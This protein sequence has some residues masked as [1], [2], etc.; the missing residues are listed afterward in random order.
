MVESPRKQEGHPQSAPGDFYVVN[1]VCISCGAPEAVAPDLIGWAD[2]GEAEPSHCIWKKQPE[3]PTELEQAI[4]AFD[5]SCCESYRYA[6]KQPAIIA[7]LPPQCCDQV[8][9][10]PDPM[11]SRWFRFFVEV[12]VGVVLTISWVIDVPRRIFRRR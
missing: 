12:L 10:P 6:G 3:T 2:V 5:A 11:D 1:D 4:A 8:E 9:Q 7:R